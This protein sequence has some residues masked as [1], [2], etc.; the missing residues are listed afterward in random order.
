M[1]DWLPGSVFGPGVVGTVA[2]FG[3]VL[4]GAAIVEVALVPGLLIGGAAVLAPRLLP[5]DMLR[6]L[7]GRRGAALSPTAAAATKHSVEAPVSGAPAPFDAWRAAVKTITYR[8]MVTTVDFG[9]NYFVIGELAT[10]AGLS[11]VCWW[12][13][14]SPISR[15]KRLGI[16]PALFRRGMPIR[17]TPRSMCRFRVRLRPAV[18]AR[19]SK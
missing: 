19:G 4:A 7:R 17:S 18:A 10:A 8:V 5:R 2:T 14:R 15:M 6:G 12:P 13:A 9:A 11:S 1:K 16:I 3:V